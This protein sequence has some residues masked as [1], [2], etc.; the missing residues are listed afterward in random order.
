MADGRL[1]ILTACAVAA[2]EDTEVLQRILNSNTTEEAVGYIEDHRVW[3]AVGE[4][5][6]KYLAERTYGEVEIETA[7]FSFE[8]GKL[9]ES[10]EVTDE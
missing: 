5:A 2:G 8:R 3:K 7:F 4:R 9:Y 6:E 10:K 1:E